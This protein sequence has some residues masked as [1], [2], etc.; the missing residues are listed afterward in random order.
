VV[1]V[2]LRWFA[3][4]ELTVAQIMMVSCGGMWSVFVKGKASGALRWF[5]KLKFDCYLDREGV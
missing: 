3:A 5:T 4:L 1:D 2:A